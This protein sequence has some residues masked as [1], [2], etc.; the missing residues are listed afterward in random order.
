MFGMNSS[1]LIFA[2]NYAYMFSKARGKKD[3]FWFTDF[4]EYSSVIKKEPAGCVA[5]VCEAGRLCKLK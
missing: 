1:V 3:R 2:Y 4:Y 5:W